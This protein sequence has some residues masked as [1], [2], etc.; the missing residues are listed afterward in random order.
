MQFPAALAKISR[1]QCLTCMYPTGCV[2]ARPAAL[3]RLLLPACCGELV[4]CCG[5][6]V[7]VRWCF[8]LD[9]HAVCYCCFRLMEPAVDCKHSC[10]LGF[11]WLCHVAHVLALC[12]CLKGNCFPCA[13]VLVCVRKGC[14]AICVNGIHALCGRCW[15]EPDAVTRL[16]AAACC[17]RHGSRPVLVL[18]WCWP[19]QFWIR[20]GGW[21]L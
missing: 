3:W 20:T 18:V 1:R 7:P 8:Y 15:R 12:I 10:R 19:V 9:H 21:C 2:C 16:P 6:T 11:V 13:F 17:L 4:T 14:I 5:S